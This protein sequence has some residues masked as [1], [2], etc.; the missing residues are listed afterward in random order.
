MEAFLKL[1]IY[2]EWLLKRH[3]ENSP[4]SQ[5]EKT[6]DFEKSTVQ[7]KTATKSLPSGGEK[8]NNRDVPHM[9][10]LLILTPKLEISLTSSP[11]SMYVHYNREAYNLKSRADC[12]P[13][14][15]SK[16]F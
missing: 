3:V 14:P 15:E 16:H 6:R 13:K 7:K 4:T 8:H 5:V 11:Q 9:G 2:T 12:R 1:H 10:Y